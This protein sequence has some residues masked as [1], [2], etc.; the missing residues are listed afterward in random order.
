MPTQTDKFDEFLRQLAPLMPI[1]RSIEFACVAARHGSEWILISGKAVLSTEPC[2]S[3]AQIV[4]VVQSQVHFM[5]AD[6]WQIYSGELWLE[7]VVAELKMAKETILMLSPVSV[8]R[9][10][11]NFEAGGAFFTDKRIIPV[12]FGGLA[13]FIYAR[14]RC[15]SIKTGTAWS[16]LLIPAQKPV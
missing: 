10:W 8:G 3:E 12:C 7:R 1:Y 14:K 2:A 9:P 4:P 16:G 11:V 15:T 13:E 5:S 6:T